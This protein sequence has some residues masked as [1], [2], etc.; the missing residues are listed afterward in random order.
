LPVR[1]IVN[2]VYPFE[3]INWIK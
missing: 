3:S 2:I 1:C